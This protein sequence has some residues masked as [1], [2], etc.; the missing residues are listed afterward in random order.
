MNISY[1]YDPMKVMD[2]LNSVDSI[3]KYKICESG[4]V[5]M[6]YDR[7]QEEFN[8]IFIVALVIL[9]ACFVQAMLFFSNELLFKADQDDVFKFNNFNSISCWILVI[10]YF[11]QLYDMGR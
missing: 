6:F 3:F 11:Y 8:K 5:R 2:A 10:F 9:I 4:L 1:L 7:L